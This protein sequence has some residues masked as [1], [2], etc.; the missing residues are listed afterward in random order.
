MI[1]FTD[2][3]MNGWSQTW[4]QKIRKVRIYQKLCDQVFKRSKLTQKN[5][6]LIF[7]ANTFS[8]NCKKKFIQKRNSF[9]NFSKMRRQKIS[10]F[11]FLGQFWPLKNLITKFLVN[12]IFSYFSRNQVWDSPVSIGIKVI[13]IPL[14]QQLVCR[15]VDASQ[16]KIQ[17]RLRLHGGFLFGTSLI[18]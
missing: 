6:T 1:Y 17:G 4:F 3:K 7:F 12:S 15:Y 16:K 13:I 5:E 10:K 2:L 9:Y 14:E 18:E 11:R 8:K